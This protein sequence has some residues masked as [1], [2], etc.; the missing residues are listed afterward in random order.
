MPHIVDI[1][2]LSEVLA[3]NVNTLRKRWRQIPHFFVG[4]GNNLKGARFDVED[5]IN[6]L[7]EES[8]GCLA[9]IHRLVFKALTELHVGALFPRFATCLLDFAA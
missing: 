5:V 4:E 9:Q 1:H 6:F 3:T 2:G 7:K 8:Y